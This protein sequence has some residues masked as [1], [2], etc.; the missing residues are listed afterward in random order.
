M[1]YKI[2]ANAFKPAPDAPLLSRWLR[3]FEQSL[4]LK[5]STNMRYEYEPKELS[6]KLQFFFGKVV[7]KSGKVSKGQRKRKM[8]HL[9]VRR[10]VLNRVV[11]SEVRS[12]CTELCGFKRWPL[13]KKNLGLCRP[14][15]PS[16]GRETPRVCIPR[17]GKMYAHRTLV[18]GLSAGSAQ[19]MFQPRERGVR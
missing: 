19:L 10:A 12:R 13:K 6:E 11:M 4:W 18:P 17:D 7:C 9:C 14:P 3:G 1:T 15:K 16:S 5:S 2:S 8:L